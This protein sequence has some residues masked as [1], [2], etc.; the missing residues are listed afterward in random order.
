MLS[1]QCQLP[2]RTVIS[3]HFFLFWKSGMRNVTW[4]AMLRLLHTVA[5]QYPGRSGPCLSI[6][7]LHIP[8]SKI[9]TKQNWIKFNDSNSVQICLS[10][11]FSSDS[12]ELIATPTDSVDQTELVD[13]SKIDWYFKKFLCNITCLPN[14]VYKSFFDVLWFRA[15]VTK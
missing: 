1:R 15:V 12:E 4:A 5:G 14:W 8:P 6:R 11:S 7:K 2:L 3:F 10:G 13:F 9:Y